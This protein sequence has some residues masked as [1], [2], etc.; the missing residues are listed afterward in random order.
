MVAAM[1]PDVVTVWAKCDVV[2]AGMPVSRWADLRIHS[3][4]R[5]VWLG[6]EHLLYLLS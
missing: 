6:C 2:E 5:L 3:G 4:W 1:V